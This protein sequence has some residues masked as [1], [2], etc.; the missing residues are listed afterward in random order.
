MAGVR[1]SAHRR[2]DVLSSLLSDAAAGENTRR[3]FKH[4]T[5]DPQRSRNSHNRFNRHAGSIESSKGFH[6]SMEWSPGRSLSWYMKT[7]NSTR[8][9]DLA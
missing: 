9:D 3:Q 8:S 7:S 4:D 1:N 6:F 5:E 2:W